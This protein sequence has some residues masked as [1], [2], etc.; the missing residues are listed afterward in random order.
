MNVPEVRM[1]RQGDDGKRRYDI[2]LEIPELIKPGKRDCAINGMNVVALLAPLF[3]GPFVESTGRDNGPLGVKPFFL[4]WA[5]VQA[6]RS[7][8]EGA[9]FW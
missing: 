1:W 6:S 9:V 7:G 5:G 4:E 3:P 8:V 2:T